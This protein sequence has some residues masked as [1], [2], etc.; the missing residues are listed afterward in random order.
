MPSDEPNENAES[1]ATLCASACGSECDDASCSSK[2]MGRNLRPDLFLPPGVLPPPRKVDISDNLK[3][4]MKRITNKF[5]PGQSQEEQSAMIN[6][7]LNESSEEGA[8]SFMAALAM[9]HLQHSKTASTDK[10]MER[11]SDTSMSTS[12][13]ETVNGRQPSQATHHR[14]PPAEATRGTRRW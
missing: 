6:A 12:T 3:T 10:A 13:A 7:L 2:R 9:H 5:K 4:N 1:T 14:P 8:Q 11:P